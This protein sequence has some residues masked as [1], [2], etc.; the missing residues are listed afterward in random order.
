[1]RKNI[2]MVMINMKDYYKILG[3]TDGA[4]NVTINRAHRKLSLKYHPDKN[5]GDAL[6]KDKFIELQEA[7]EILI[8]PVKLEEYR[9]ARIT[10]LQFLPL[11][12]GMDRT[13]YAW[14]LGIEGLKAFYADNP[15]EIINPG[16]LA[17]CLKQA[18]P[19]NNRHF[20]ANYYKN[21]YVLTTD[22][23]N[24]KTEDLQCSDI[25]FFIQTK[26]RAFGSS[27]VACDFLT[28]PITREIVCKILLHFLKGQYFGDNL[29]QIKDYLRKNASADKLYV[30]V[31]DILGIY[32]LQAEHVIAS[33][34]IHMLYDAVYAQYQGFAVQIARCEKEKAGLQQASIKMRFLTI[35]VTQAEQD[36]RTEQA[37]IIQLQQELFKLTCSKDSDLG[38]VN[39]KVAA[40]NEK[41]VAAQLRAKEL[42][43]K[44]QEAKEICAFSAIFQGMLQ[45]SIT[46]I[47]EELLKL[48]E[49]QIPGYFLDLIDSNYFKLFLATSLNCALQDDEPAVSQA[50]L[51][52][53]A[54]HIKENDL[55]SVRQ[56]YSAFGQMLV[57]VDTTLKNL[58]SIEA[59]EQDYYDAAAFFYDVASSAVPAPIT[60]DAFLATGLALQLAASKTNNSAAAM[61]YENMALQ[62]YQGIIQIALHLPVPDTLY[63]MTHLSKYLKDFKF[64]ISTI[65]AA[66]ATKLLAQMHDINMR[67][68]AAEYLRLDVHTGTALD[69]LAG[70]ID[71]SLYF[72]SFMPS[73]SQHLPFL[74]RLHHLE[75][76]RDL[77]QKSLERFEEQC[78]RQDAVVA[79]NPQVVDKIY[80]LYKQ[81][82][83]DKKTS[84]AKLQRLYL[85]AID[86][87]LKEAGTTWAAMNTLINAP[88]IDMRQD[89]Q[90]F[91]LPGPLYYPPEA[92]FY[93][94]CYGFAVH[95]KTSEIKMLLV[96]ASSPGESIFMR[97][98][99]EELQHQ[100]INR[101][102]LSLDG[103]HRDFDPL[104]TVVLSPPQIK[105]TALASAEL[106]ADYQVLKSLGQGT[107][108]SGM[109]PFAKRQLTLLQGLPQE[110][111]DDLLV[112][113]N[114]SERK[115]G[116][117]S[118]FWFV[119]GEI[120]YFETDQGDWHLVI[121]GKP[122]VT[123]QQ[124]ALVRGLDGL[125]RDAA[126][127]NADDSVEAQYASN[128]TKH[129][130]ILCQHLP[131]LAKMRELYKVTGVISQLQAIRSSHQEMLAQNM[132]NLGSEAYWHNIHDQQR[133]EWTKNLADP[134]YWLDFIAKRRAYYEKLLQDDA[135]WETLIV[136]KCAELSEQKANFSTAAG[137]QEKLQE[138]QQVHNL[139]FELLYSNTP[140]LAW[141]VES[142]EFHVI[143]D[144]LK[145][146]IADDINADKGLQFIKIASKEKLKTKLS[147]FKEDL[148]KY[149]YKLACDNF[150]QGDFTELAQ[151][152]A[153][154]ALQTQSQNANF[155]LE[156][157][158]VLD[159]VNAEL[160]QKHE[161]EFLSVIQKIDARMFKAAYTQDT[162]EFVSW[163]NEK[164]ALSFE[165]TKNSNIAIWNKSPSAA[166]KQINKLLDR[167]FSKQ[168]ALVS[169]NKE[170]QELQTQFSQ[171]FAPLFSGSLP[172]CNAALEAFM[173]GNCRPL[174]AI[175]VMPKMAAIKQAMNDGDTLLDDDLQAFYQLVLAA[176]ISQQIHKLQQELL[177]IRSLPLD[178]QTSPD[179]SYL[180]VYLTAEF[181]DKA[182]AAFMQHDFSFFV[183]SQVQQGLAAL[184]QQLSQDL[185]PQ[186]E[187]F[188]NG[189]KDILRNNLSSHAE[190]D[191]NK[192]KQDWTN[193]IDSCLQKYLELEK[194]SM[195]AEIAAGERLESGFRNFKLGLAPDPLTP[196]DT[197]LRVPA[198][199]T[200][201]DDG[202]RVYGGVKA[203][204]SFKKMENIRYDLDFTNRMLS[205][206]TDLTRTY[207]ISRAR[208]ALRGIS[209][210]VDISTQLA[211]N[212]LEQQIRFAEMQQ[213]V[214]AM[215]AG[216]NRVQLPASSER[217]W[218]IEE[219]IEPPPYG[220]GSSW[221]SEPMQY[222]QRAIVSN[223]TPPANQLQAWR[224]AQIPVPVLQSATVS[225]VPRAPVST[226][227]TAPTA[228]TIVAASG[229]GNGSSSDDPSGSDDSDDEES[230]KITHKRVLTVSAQ[231]N[232][233]DPGITSRLSDAARRAVIF[234]TLVAATTS[235]TAENSSSFFLDMFDVLSKNPNANVSVNN[236]LE[237][238][239]ILPSPFGLS[240]AIYSHNTAVDNVLSILSNGVEL[241][242]SRTNIFSQPSAYF[243]E[244]GYSINARNFGATIV[245]RP[246]KQLKIDLHAYGR[247]W[248]ILPAEVIKQGYDGVRYDGRP[249]YNYALFK[250]PRNYLQP[251]AVV[252]NTTSILNAGWESAI[253]KP[254]VYIIR[255]VT[256]VSMGYA[257]YDAAGEIIA[258][259]SPIIETG[260]QGLR[261]GADY[262]AGLA[263]ADA[264]ILPCAVVGSWA[265]PI[266]PITVPVCLFGA[267]ATV[268][269]A[270]DYLVRQ[271]LTQTDQFL[272]RQQQLGFFDKPKP[273]DVPRDLMFR[274]YR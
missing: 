163:Y 125:L 157:Q 231:K 222:A 85:Q 94:E 224:V 235:S 201:K 36:L 180:N 71:R 107:E 187:K 29:I 207:D 49:Q 271:S 247:N 262:Y 173:S 123:I 158:G 82:T 195:R 25:Y 175:K 69:S 127:N 1:M 28:Q 4:D 42:A 266:A 250:E 121:F 211:V 255:G 232:P 136:E 272:R 115:P 18:N 188:I 67:I 238:A 233:E 178:Q 198:I 26:Q 203:D 105:G 192:L 182:I 273:K 253:S 264:F 45:P 81:A 214:N 7:Y 206:S 245:F 92:Q 21:L 34:A 72:V 257:L 172:E 204:P 218:D 227:S 169:F 167:D 39:A 202:C 248:D 14:R 109:P 44:Y 37:Q 154:H 110:V 183:E 259:P 100:G 251:V 90:G 117:A 60:I 86:L 47:D 244:G 62:T 93:K 59:S 96:P 177:R 116:S 53:I 89:K 99:A 155:S 138:L 65:N 156:V 165:A 11:P 35:L 24:G 147:I 97:E 111:Q 79:A 186:A 199:F 31:L 15:A 237:P 217:L 153:Q 131:I 260:K 148:A 193:D 246:I 56:T 274:M 144:S 145:T 226:G 160:L 212:S 70:T 216:G 19:L 213:R 196:P 229:R 9:Q 185:R 17:E 234:L 243:A 68:A 66:D 219:P 261:L 197:S 133:A 118:R 73:F 58:A 40:Y 140:E 50:Q 242:A 77:M 184:Q 16:E 190:H 33:Q 174:A 74:E 135:Y 129:Y 64:K 52:S 76:Y 256:Y 208:D 268:S 221:F 54:S 98:E 23:A 270:T 146:Q 124:Q 200:N 170:R 132:Q 194:H 164:R 126:G 249:G 57:H 223:L 230:V 3:I 51:A 88:Y 162:P 171:A 78:K 159:S 176:E 258:S 151:A 38:R 10:A 83:V 263:A 6:A 152:L 20:S 104:Q 91:C 209:G 41:L 43:T 179:Y 150:M 137:K 141:T 122:E 241:R 101:S 119:H 191:A 87:L 113:A 120:P 189:Q 215:M 139:V 63:I 32:N 240:S 103:S 128:M 55:D 48:K 80:Y 220:A 13:S 239:P 2:F 269:L 225:A 30:A 8:D 143:H 181:Y 205:A 142:P 252:P 161:Q 46:A 130:E 114:N 95:Q 134:Q 236:N 210:S 265:P 149:A 106:I 27:E 75:F 102:S 168:S 166:T 84:P 5:P 22:T 228:R 108:M 12:P 112:L 267:A 61:A 254:V